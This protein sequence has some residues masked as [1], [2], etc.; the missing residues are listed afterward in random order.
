MVELISTYTLGEFV[1]FCAILMGLVLAGVK[2]FNYLNSQFH[3]VET[4]RTKID[5]LNAKLDSLLEKVEKNEEDTQILKEASISRIKGKIVDRHK[6]YMA[7]GRID[8]RT[9]DYLQAQFRAYEKM[10]G[11]SYVHELMRD[12]EG[13]PLK[14]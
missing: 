12:L 11:N 10:G 9:L 7:L 8:Y 5:N 3:F 4:K 13:L 14:D 6:Q 2:L 1:G